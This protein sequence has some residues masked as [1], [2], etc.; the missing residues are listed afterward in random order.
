MSQP[1]TLLRI[2]RKRNEEPLEALLVDDPKIKVSR[3][4]AAGAKYFRLADTFDTSGF[5]E[6]EKTRQLQEKIASKSFTTS[7]KQSASIPNSDQVTS[8]SLCSP[9]FKIISRNDV[10]LDDDTGFKTSSLVH[11]YDAI[12]ETVPEP[13]ILDVFD[14]LK[15]PQAAMGIQSDE[16]VCNLLP[17]IREFLS[18]KDAGERDLDRQ[19][20]IGQV[21]SI[22]NPQDETDKWDRVS[23]ANDIGIADDYVYDF[24]FHDENAIDV[25]TNT[26]VGSLVWVEDDIVVLDEDDVESDQ[27]T[28][29]VDSNA[30]D[31]Y[32]NDYPE[33]DGNE[34]AWSDLVDE[35]SNP[36]LNDD[37][38]DDDDYNDDDDDHDYEMDTDR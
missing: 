16:L 9:R 25:L 36:F 12:K 33:E 14:A 17:M 23:P 27:N 24:Y 38:D 2:K 26:K 18:L 30:E 35:R 10:V 3:T 7:Q 5:D 11:M 22:E 6:I 4:N 32:G 37:D 29:D 20:A 8:P 19:K 1:V 15:N 28:D 34:E 13:P 21:E 31:Y